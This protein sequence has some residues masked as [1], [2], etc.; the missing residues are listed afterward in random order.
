VDYARREYMKA[1][2][3]HCG[4]SLA[5]IAKHWDRSSERTLLKLIREFD[6]EAELQA[7]RR[8]RK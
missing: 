6:L 3:E 4:G 8:K 7:A 1:L 5:D 2:I